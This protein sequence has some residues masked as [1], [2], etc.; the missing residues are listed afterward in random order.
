MLCVKLMVA[1]MALRLLVITANAAEVQVRFVTNG[2]ATTLVGT[3]T[4]S[5]ANAARVL[6]AE[7]INLGTATNQDT[8]D[9]IIQRL[10]AE[11]I[12]DTKTIER[13]ATVVGDI[14]VTP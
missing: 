6:A 12:G 4:I 8:V 13:N 11:M 7:K 14:S 10:L 3:R 1:V 5:D 9:A 2:G